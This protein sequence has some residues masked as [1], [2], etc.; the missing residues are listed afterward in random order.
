MKTIPTASEI[1]SIS[2]IELSRRLRAREI[3]AVGLLR[4]T[5]DRIDR[6]NPD[7]NAIVA[8]R[9]GITM[10]ESTCASIYL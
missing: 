6:V 5:L 7:V 3:T 8:L 1:L 4:A 10:E 9:K 2:A